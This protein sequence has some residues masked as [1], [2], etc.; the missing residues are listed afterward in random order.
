[1]TVSALKRQDSSTTERQ[2]YCSYNHQDI[3]DAELVNLDLCIDSQNNHYHGN[4]DG[5]PDTPDQGRALI[6]L[7]NWLCSGHVS[8]CRRSACATCTLGGYEV[9]KQAVSLLSGQGADANNER[10]SETVD[11]VKERKV[12]VYILRLI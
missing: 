3:V 2:T 1:M 8:F 11:E 6:L 4:D 9:L 12:T 5:S 7:L 10:N